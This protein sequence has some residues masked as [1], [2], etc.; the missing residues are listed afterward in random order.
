MLAWPLST[1]ALRHRPGHQSLPQRRQ[2]YTDF[3]AAALAESMR[4]A[5]AL[6]GRVLLWQPGTQ[7]GAMDGDCGDIWL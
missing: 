2:H 5:A 7:H 3:V 1:M 4:Q 6:G